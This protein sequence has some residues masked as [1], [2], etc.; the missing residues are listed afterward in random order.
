MAIT[1]WF[2][3]SLVKKQSMSN[4]IFRFFIVDLITISTWYFNYSLCIFR[5]LL[6][7]V[8]DFWKSNFCKV[9]ATCIKL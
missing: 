3:Y 5:P 9:K 8:G 1:L 4:F 2:D 6:Q 7:I